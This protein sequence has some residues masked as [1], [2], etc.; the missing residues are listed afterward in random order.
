MTQGKIRKETYDW[1]R[2]LQVWWDKEREHLQ[3]QRVANR[4]GMINT[5]SKGLSILQLKLS[6]SCAFILKFKTLKNCTIYEKKEEN[7][8]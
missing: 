4:A 2:Y 6:F 1:D 8:N 7:P 3:N 5:G